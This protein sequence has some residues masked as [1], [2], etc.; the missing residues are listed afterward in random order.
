MNRVIV[1][2]ASCAFLAYGSAI[3][4]G[5]G[6]ARTHAGDGK[7][8]RTDRYGDP[9]PDGVVARLGTPRLCQGEACL[10]FS[11]DARLLAIGK[12]D[13]GV[14]VCEVQ[15]GKELWRADKPD[16]R[17]HYTTVGYSR[18]AC[19]PDGK[20]LA[21]GLLDMD[22][23]SRQRGG[24]RAGAKAVIRLWDVATGRELPQLQSEVFPRFVVFAPV[25]RSLAVA[26][27]RG[28]IE[29]WDPV[30]GKLLRRLGHPDWITG[31]AF[32]P[33]GKMLSVLGPDPSRWRGRVFSVRDVATGAERSWNT[34]RTGHPGL[35]PLAPDGRCFAVFTADARSIVLLDTATG[36][37]RCR[38]EVDAS[39]PPIRSAIIA[40]SEDG[41][42]LTATSRDE[43][44]PVWRTS[45]GKRLCRLRLCP[46][47]SLSPFEESND[48]SR[49]SM[50]A[51]TIL[52][53]LDFEASI[54]LSRDGK[55]LAWTGRI[56]QGVHL[57]DV[58][59]ER[60]LHAFPGHR[61]GPLAVAFLPD[62]R[63][64]AT[65]NR[66]HKW[67]FPV[68]PRSADWSLCRWDAASGTELAVTRTYPGGAVRLTA[69]S[70]DGRLAATVI[71]DGTLRLWDVVAGKE[72]RHWQVPT[73]HGRGQF[74][75]EVSKEP[76]PLISE[77]AF[78]PDGKVL[79]AGDWTGVCCWEVATG[80]ELPPFKLP[81]AYLGPFRCFAAP[82]G[83]TLL[84]TASVASQPGYARPEREVLGRVVLLDA[85]SG[86]VLRALPAPSTPHCCAFAPDGKTLAVTV[87]GEPG[88]Q[89]WE[90][91]SGQERG[92]L[93][94]PGTPSRSTVTG[95]VFSPDSRVLAAA[96]RVPAWLR[97]WDP[98][99]GRV[100]GRLAAPPDLVESLAFSPDG[101]RLAVGGRE[102]TALVCDVAALRGG[103]LPGVAR[104]PA[105]ELDDLWTD[106]TGPDGPRAYRAIGRLA[107]SPAESVPFL[108]R[109]FQRLP[110]VDE[111]GLARLI[112]DLDADEFTVRE[113]ATRALEG[114]GSRAEPA[115]RQ[116]LEDRPSAEVRS[117]VERLLEKL[118]S[119]KAPPSPELI[120]LRMLEALEHSDSPVAR[121]ALTE[122][123]ADAPESRLAQEAKAA[124]A[125]LAR[126]PPSEP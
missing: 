115:L 109:R 6:E 36:Q 25:G 97:L 22:A 17:A 9:L 68:G 31:L 105:R 70:A 74:N 62:G 88:V 123:A 89:L 60:E 111:R 44:L 67:T 107:A 46:F 102:N 79:L 71:H 64:V 93:Q 65:L 35:G 49:L 51:R 56:D 7:P 57:W 37:E 26:A 113:Q 27:E 120:G 103:P 106:L 100:V 114:L 122:V 121:Q 14:S 5:D 4:A 110:V 3:R 10:A 2:L 78:S 124:L 75:S 82:D 45:D 43:F 41:Q 119:G 63:T 24:A 73:G 48:P 38:T 101:T 1:L 21:F 23:T 69:F 87:P 30:Q 125:R 126:R 85:A 84:L 18:L 98:A 99:S 55:L 92:R 77:P 13:G 95:L 86:R 72:L 108:K 83:R 66:D 81:P 112:A 47:P 12:P 94:T 58:A 91:A 54:A 53:M 117:R 80:K 116:A 42:V 19:S 52:S 104:L 34:L 33:D 32:T 29:V 40:F 39:G 76:Y 8:V 20:V 59:R 118:K 96:G 90:V 16:F 61:H 50:E 11:P 15:T 28:T